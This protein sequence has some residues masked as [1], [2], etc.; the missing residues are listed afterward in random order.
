MGPERGADDCEPILLPAPPDVDKQRGGER[1]PPP[2]LRELVRALCV[3]HLGRRVPAERGGVELRGGGRERAAI[4]PV[5][6]PGG[7]EH[8]LHVRE[9][10]RWYRLLCVSPERRREHVGSESPKGNGKF[11]QAD[12][13]GNVAEWNLD[14]HVDPYVVTCNN[15]SYLPPGSSSRVVRGGSFGD[16]DGILLASFRHYFLPAPPRNNYVGA[17]CARTP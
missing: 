6:E 16:Y 9:L 5:V 11:G 1:E 3:L 15:C 10:L 17:R 14:W 12:L 4:L 7:L 2:Q 8:R 13:G